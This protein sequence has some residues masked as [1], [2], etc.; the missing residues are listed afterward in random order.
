MIEN[1]DIRHVRIGLLVV[2]LPAWAIC[3]LPGWRLH[4]CAGQTT[5]PVRWLLYEW[6]SRCFENYGWTVLGTRN[7]V[8]ASAAQAIKTALVRVQMM[9]RS[10]CCIFHNCA[11]R[12]YR[13]SIIMLTSRNRTAMTDLHE[14]T[15]R[16]D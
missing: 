7:F 10:T 13:L 2:W 16:R 11:V 1:F 8:L 3:S 6:I 15:V 4:A 5:S 9:Y 12:C 14:I